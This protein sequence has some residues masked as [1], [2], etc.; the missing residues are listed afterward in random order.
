[1]P[2]PYFL[3]PLLL[4]SACTIQKDLLTA[5]DD[6]SAS[7]DGATD[8]EL[9]DDTGGSTP[10]TEPMPT[11]QSGPDSETGEEV[12][13]VSAC[14]EALAFRD[15][16]VAVA[17]Q[18]VVGC[19]DCGAHETLQSALLTVDPD[20]NSRTQFAGSGEHSDPEALAI[21]DDGALYVGGHVNAI[22]MPEAEPGLL[23]KFAPDG[24]LLWSVV[25]A[26]GSVGDL[27]VRG[28]EIVIAEGNRSLQARSAS[29]GAGLWE[30]PAERSAIAVEVDGDGGLHVAGRPLVAGEPELTVYIAR[31][32][33]DRTLL[34]EDVLA[35]PEG[36]LSLAVRG[37]ALDATGGS[38]FAVG[39]DTGVPGSTVTRFHKYDGDGQV[40]WSE[41]SAALEADDRIEHFLA[42]PGGGA[43]AVGQGDS[44]AFTLAL[45]PGGATLWSDRH[46]P[47]GLIDARNEAAA[48]VDG[49]L[50]VAGCGLG[51]VPNTGSEGWVLTFTP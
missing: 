25:L 29:D 37:L 3:C 21:A 35:L 10:T 5:G 4:L 38:I 27:A 18:T 8:T 22:D 7:A 32:A 41:T 45:G 50:V 12:L 14:I 9:G 11:T 30:L 40:V 24:E 49:E 13:A 6:A 26:A 20:D 15:V 36:A 28:Q 48:I 31:H 42:R 33:A 47:A 43:I 1:M 34:W 46:A 2:Y 51:E 39:E 19:P 17:R 16:L 44:G 23:H